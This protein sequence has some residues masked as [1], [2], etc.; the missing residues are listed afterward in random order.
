MKNSFL[1]I[2]DQEYCLKL[3]KEAFDLPFIQQLVKRIQNEARLIHKHNSINEEDI[4]SK[5]ER[6][7]RFERLDSLEDK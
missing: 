4:K 1:E 2:T 7:E 3:H 6:F 5:R